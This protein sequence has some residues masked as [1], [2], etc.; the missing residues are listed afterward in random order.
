MTAASGTANLI[1]ELS[2]EDNAALS[3]VT[4]NAY[5]VATSNPGITQVRSGKFPEIGTVLQ[6]STSP[7]AGVTFA[8]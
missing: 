4:V 1:R 3:A 2:G 6:V 8:T 7:A 5:A